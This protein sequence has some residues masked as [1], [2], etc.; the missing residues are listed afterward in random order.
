MFFVN[1]HTWTWN[2]ITTSN[3]YH[4]MAQPGTI[5][6]AGTTR[7]TV[8]DLEQTHTWP[9]IIP[10]GRTNTH[11]HTTYTLFFQLE[12]TQYIHS[13]FHWMHECSISR[14]LYYL[15]SCYR[16]QIPM[17]AHTFNVMS[18]QNRNHL[19][20]IIITHVHKM[21][22]FSYFPYSKITPYTRSLQIHFHDT[23]CTFISTSMFF[24][25]IITPTKTG[26]C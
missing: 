8:P 3:H 2:L 23:S 26:E 25:S 24:V 4:S 17:S 20:F 5:G 15:S 11:K 10:L 14:T 9:K 19:Y 18:R 16:L 22:I 13:K 1:S 21:L 6:C 12:Y 7:R